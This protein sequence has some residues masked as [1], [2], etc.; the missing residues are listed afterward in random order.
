M[1]TLTKSSGTA[2]TTTGTSFVVTSGKKFRI[3]H[4]SLSLR[5]ASAATSPT[6]IFNFR[7]NTG[8]AAIASSTPIILAA[9]CATPAVALEFDRNSIPLGEGMEILGDGT[10]QFGVSCLA[11]FANQ[12][13][14]DVLIIGYEY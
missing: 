6:A 4:I 1:V 11:S 13:T 7:V 2:A 10:L 8:G 12:P 14:I 3:T 5:N 9:R